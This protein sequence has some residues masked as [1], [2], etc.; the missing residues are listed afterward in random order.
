MF[1]DLLD[2][3]PALKSSMRLLS[4]AYEISLDIRCSLWDALYLSLGKQE[5]CPVVT[6][7]E[8]LIKNVGGKFDVRRLTDLQ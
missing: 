2:E 7:D 4:D 8:K 1:V 6:A 3:R 5:Q